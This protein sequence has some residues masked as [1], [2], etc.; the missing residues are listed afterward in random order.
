MTLEIFLEN[1]PR[2]PFLSLFEKQVTQLSNVVPAWRTDSIVPIPP[3]L[4]LLRLD[5]NCTLFYLSICSVRK[6]ERGPEYGLEL[7]PSNQA[8]DRAT[9]PLRACAPIFVERI[10]NRALEF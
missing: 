10:A 9:C 1:D 6:Q 4:P 7:P 2:R 5:P 8:I 3:S